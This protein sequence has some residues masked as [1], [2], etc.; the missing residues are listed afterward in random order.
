MT[1]RNYVEHND[2]VKMTSPIKCAR[3]C[4]VRVESGGVGGKGKAAG[5]GEGVVK[6][7]GGLQ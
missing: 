6:L 4:F 7:R 2:P 3:V 1:I 5:F